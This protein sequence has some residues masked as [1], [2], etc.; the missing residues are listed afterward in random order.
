M[1]HSFILALVI[2][3]SL[4]PDGKAQLPTSA[5]VDYAVR[6][7]AI[8][9]ERLLDEPNYPS[10]GNPLQ[11]TWNMKGVG[12]WTVGFYGGSLW[13]LYKLTGDNY[14]R[15]LALEYQERIKERQYDTSNHDVGC[16]K[17]FIN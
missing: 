3:A 16:K 8:L 1:K 4:V 5:I 17:Q 2:T 11:L 15:T 13:M 7:Y 14:W 10:T 6:Q 12:D 9:S